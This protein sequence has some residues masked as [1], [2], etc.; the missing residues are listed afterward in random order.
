MRKAMKIPWALGLAVLWILFKFAGFNTAIGGVLGMT[1]VVTS[2][3]IIVVEFYKSGDISLKSFFTDLVWAIITFGVVCVS[4]TKLYDNV[5][6]GSFTLP[7]LFVGMVSLVD[8][9]LSTFNSYRTAQRNI[10]SNFEH[11]DVAA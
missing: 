1:I 4:M 10:S 11:A 2:V 6:L 3:I 9:S 8:I 5:G 7:D